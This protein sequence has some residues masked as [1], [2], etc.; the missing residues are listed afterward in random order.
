VMDSGRIVESGDHATLL[1]KRGA[2]AGLIAAQ[3]ESPIDPVH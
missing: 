2:Y 3:L 1:D